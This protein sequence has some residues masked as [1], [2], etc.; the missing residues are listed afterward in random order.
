MVTVNALREDKEGDMF[1]QPSEEAHRRAVRRDGATENGRH[2]IALFGYDF[3]H[4]K[5]CN[6]ILALKSWRYDVV[7]VLAAPWRKLNITRS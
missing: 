3:P 4:V 1:A 7:C 6:F 5:T 2:R